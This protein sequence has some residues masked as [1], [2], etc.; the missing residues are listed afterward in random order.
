MKREKIYAGAIALALSLGAIAPIGENLP[1]YASEIEKSQ[2]QAVSTS[3]VSKE[4]QALIDEQ[5]GVHEFESYLNASDSEKNNYDAAIDQA[6]DAKN[7]SDESSLIEKIV[8]AK[9]NLGANSTKTYEDREALRSTIAMAK[10]LKDS[11]KNTDITKEDSNKLSS[12]IK[13]AE[14]TLNSNSVDS[15]TINNTNQNLAGLINDL[16]SKYKLDGSSALTGEDIDSLDQTNATSYGKARDSLMNLINEVSELPGSDK[17]KNLS[18]L[19]IASDLTNA[20]QKAKEVYENPNSSTEDL[21]SSY[22]DLNSAYNKV[23]S[24][25]DK[26]DTEK[27]RL[28]DQIK[29]YADKPVGY[30]K[31]SKSAQKT[32]DEAKREA[33]EISSSE[34]AS[35]EEL[36]KSLNNLKLATLT[37]APVPTKTIDKDT[38][39]SSTSKESLDSLSEEARD[40]ESS[41]LES[42]KTSLDN[43][44]RASNQVKANESYKLATEEKKKA[45]DE[46]I[47]NAKTLL[48]KWANS[49]SFSKDEFDKA[50]DDLTKA[51][52]DL[53]YTDSITSSTSLQKLVDEASE[54]R[55]S[56]DFLDKESSE[57][58]EDKALINTY[59]SLIEKSKNLL[60][61]NDPDPQLLQSYVDR[62]NNVKK[63]INGQ[64]SV[65]EL[66]LRSLVT[67][68]K[69]FETSEEF[70]EA[71]NSDNQIIKE[72]TE[73]YEKLIE[74]ANSYINSAN[75]DK[76]KTK[77]YIDA[78]NKAKNLI[79]EP[80]KEN[81]NTYHL[82]K[83]I[84]DARKAISHKDFK[85]RAQVERQ[86]L[87]KA[88]KKALEAIDS[89]KD[90]D[91]EDAISPLEEALK[92]LIDF[93]SKSE[94]SLSKL[95]IEELL[96]LAYKVMDHKDYKTDVF[97]TQAKNLV[98]AV[99]AAEAARKTD[100]LTDK[101]IAKLALINALNQNEI[102]PI[103]D[104]IGV[105]KISDDNEDRLLSSEEIIEKIIREDESF[106][107]SKKYTKAQKSLRKAYDKEL[108]EA[109]TLLEKENLTDEELKDKAKALEK[110]KEALD[111]D[112][113]DDKLKSIKD[114]LEKHGSS[115]ADSKLRDDL[116]KKINDIANDQKAS[117]DDLLSLETE[118]N[119][120]IPKGSVN[121]SNTPVTT[122]TTTTT[123]APQARST[124]TPVTTTRRVPTTVNPGS[125]VRTGIKSLAGIIVILALAIGA[126]VLTGRNKNK[127]E[128]RGEDNDEI[129]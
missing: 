85:K 17:Y 73:D 81:A 75:L 55:K 94:D 93:D 124:T 108:A 24:A 31:A 18:K 8:E 2:D 34:N 111:G 38:E 51:L 95:S 56:K 28:K 127:N 21:L 42:L 12:A 64:Y 41:K 53:G 114:K 128:R 116:E 27:K 115:I 112:E 33:L 1:A 39:S 68:S 77:S 57:N 45:Y 14:N 78:I 49:E 50:I 3:K 19:N 122:T 118:L 79:V 10:K 46:A 125:I 36:N 22:K 70:I 40:K 47:D 26:D 80:S 129:K 74:E 90:E 59:N 92:P 66:E 91:I 63:T 54:Y 15:S 105:D 99:N 101:E 84:I 35:P 117:M 89:G 29:D 16:E 43:L 119:N 96:N 88:Y 48:T 67:A 100:S 113:F 52:S 120:A 98:D 5:N 30:D 87:E 4:L 7:S 102:R 107:S 60:D 61:T 104:E 123:A 97:Y 126:F 9:T 86:R 103:V 106:R 71:K 20:S 32:Y 58:K 25:I 62:I 76:D 13:E 65:L 69:V 44:I 109:K 121:G 37:L 72:S 11:F 83:L 82:E 23:L 6:K 110:A